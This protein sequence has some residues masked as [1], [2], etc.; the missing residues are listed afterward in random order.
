LKNEDF[1]IATN[2]FIPFL[3]QHEFDY[4]G[5]DVRAVLVTL[6]VVATSWP[7]PDEVILDILKLL[8]ARTFTPTEQCDDAN[9]RTGVLE[10]PLSER[11]ARAPEIVIAY[12]L[13]WGRPDLNRFGAPWQSALPEAQACLRAVMYVSTTRRHRL[14][15]DTDFQSLYRR[16]STTSLLLFSRNYATGDK[17]RGYPS[18]QRKPFQ[19]SGNLLP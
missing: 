3:D 10:I 11:A 18:S 19:T 14:L 1:F 15:D 2:Q 4:P 12:L 9:V 5:R 8:R 6:A 17:C 7:P 16:Q 13:G